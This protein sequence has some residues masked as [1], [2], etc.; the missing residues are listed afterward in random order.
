M[1]DEGGHMNIEIRNMIETDI[2]DFNKEFTL[3]G[4]NKPVS[5]FERY[6]DEQENGKRQVFVATV[7]NQVAGYTTL[8]PN[9]KFGAFKNMNIPTV[10]DFNVLEKYQK[11]GI[12]T[13]ILD[14]IENTVK[15]YSDKI[16]LGVGLHHG[17]GPAQRLYVKR[18]YIPDG[19]GVWYNNKV[20]EPYTD[21]KNDDGLVLY[22]LKQL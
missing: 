10:C 16:C 1:L 8:L 14:R 15:K 5:L 6:F 4:W 21:C 2:L 7:Q 12:G 13:A 17:Y 20:L 3:Q 18:G 9:D 19:S 11:Q 22:M